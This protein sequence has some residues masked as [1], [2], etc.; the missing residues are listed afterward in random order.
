MFA[1]DFRQTLS[2]VPR[3]GREQVIAASIRRSALWQHVKIHHLH[4]NQRLERTPENDA[5]AAWILDI[6]AGK[7]VDAADTIKIPQNMLC[8]GNTIQALINS[9]YPDI[10]Q[11]NHPDQYYLDRTIFS[12]KNDSVDVINSLIL[13]SFPG[14]EQIFHS[15]DTVSFREQELNNY[16]PYPAEYFKLSQSKWPS[17]F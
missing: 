2:I 9:T 4:Q 7:T 16:Q 5:H 14:E 8:Q 6:G 11:G 13:T 3:G 15:A 1:G 10:E 12:C 17:S